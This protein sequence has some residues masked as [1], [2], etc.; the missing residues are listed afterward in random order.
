MQVFGA[1]CLWGRGH[2]WAKGCLPHLC[3]QQL[4]QD[5]AAH[6]QLQKPK[7][8]CG[9]S[10]RRTLESIKKAHN[11]FVAA[12]SNLKNTKYFKNVIDE[13][14]FNIPVDQVRMS[15]V[16]HNISVSLKI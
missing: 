10:A 12:G 3:V 6:L 14:F 9:Q 15:M 1:F 13:T 2:W 7:A 4:L 11:E 16:A 5:N 8:V